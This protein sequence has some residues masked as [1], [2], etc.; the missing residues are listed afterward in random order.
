MPPRPIERYNLL[1]GKQRSGS[2]DLPNIPWLTADGIDFSKVPLDLV[3]R[4]A[5]WDEYGE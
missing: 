3:A 1:M 5:E 2:N 4:R